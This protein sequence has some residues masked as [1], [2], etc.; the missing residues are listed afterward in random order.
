M[1]ADA[2]TSRPC[3]SFQSREVTTKSARL[4]LLLPLSIRRWL[5]WASLWRDYR[6]IALDRRS[7]RAL[8]RAASPRGGEGAVKIRVKA[9]PQPLTIR[10]GT[11]DGSVVWSILS[12]STHLP[13]A[14]SPALVWDLGANIGVAAADI[15]TRYPAAR[16]VAV[17]PEPTN[18][19]LARLNAPGCEVIEAAAWTATQRLRFDAV[20]RRESGG[21]V[22]EHGGLEVD[23]ISLDDLAAR[24]GFPDFVKMDVEGAERLLLQGPCHWSSR[25]REIR[26]ECHGSYT[27]TDC[28]GD[29]EQLGFA[30]HIRPERLA[31]TTVVGVRTNGPEGGPTRGR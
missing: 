16:V 11:T 8:R 13:L 19:R 27:P 31:R 5:R 17:E 6:R 24:T 7:Y 20:P 15:Q 4:P 21:K 25:V 1:G 12:G 23:G 18:A 2:S 29:L 26:V 9:L 14:T 28:K 22:S 10:P 3:N 30:A